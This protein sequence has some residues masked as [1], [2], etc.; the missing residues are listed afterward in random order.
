[1]SSG[2]SGGLSGNG[3]AG[4]SGANAGGEKPVRFAILGAGARGRIYADYA[5]AHPEEARVVA[6]A[7]PDPARLGRMRTAFALPD[8]ACFADWAEL[9][10]AAPAADAVLV[11]TQDR[12]HVEPTVRA[13]GMGYHVL[14]EKPMATDVPDIL[15]IGRMAQ[16]SG[17]VLSVSHVLRYS[18]FFQAIKRLI[19]DGSIGRLM[20]IQHN[21]NVGYYHQAHSF[22]RGPWSRSSEASPMIMAKS[23]HD[24]D[25]LQ[26]LA[27]ANC[28][29]ISSFGMLS[30]FREDQAPE[31]AADRCLDCPLQERCLYSAP[32]FYLNPDNYGFTGYATQDFS[33]E[34]ILAALREGPYG[35]CVWRCDNDVVD[36]QVVN[37]R[38]ENDIT[39]AFTMTA[40]TAEISRTI[41]VMGTEGEIRGSMERGEVELIRFGGE[42][43]V[44]V[45]LP[46]F[47]GPAGH[48]GGDQLLMRDF[49]RLVSQGGKEEG[50]TSAAKSVQ[51][52]L[53][54]LAAERS[55][56]EGRIVRME[57]YAR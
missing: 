45:E 35:R 33:R 38:F 44:Q 27:G 6:V 57:E 50:L 19:D 25:I 23:C 51:S 8:E 41:K 17:K 34:G 18:P 49:L 36:H 46:S 55:R 56:L 32:K 22:V 52:H 4:G 3:S 20:T 9:L 13:L 37:L 31:G 14:L 53:M 21:E 28:A 43:P 7:E 42:G 1:M 16:S 47:D 30:H 26:W 29:E 12:M 48:G 11:C 40:F 2:L 39:T 10:D 54:A 15:A 24:M 5:L